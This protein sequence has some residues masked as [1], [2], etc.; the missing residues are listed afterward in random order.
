MDGG[1]ISRLIRAGLLTGVV[2]GL[3]AVMTKDAGL[4]GAGNPDRV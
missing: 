1:A 3:W 2:D 4:A